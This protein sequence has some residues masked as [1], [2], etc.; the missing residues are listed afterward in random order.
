MITSKGLYFDI[1][2]ERFVV[3]TFHSTLSTVK[4]S[5]YYQDDPDKDSTPIQDTLPSNI[6]PLS[7]AMWGWGLGEGG[8][9]K[10]VGDVAT[11]AD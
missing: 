3:M 6:I 7:S 4:Y 1:K 8:T 11:E 9:K 10:E 5:W 2:N